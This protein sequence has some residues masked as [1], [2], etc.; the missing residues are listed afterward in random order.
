[1]RGI[2]FLGLTTVLFWL[3]VG[4]A[5]TESFL[6]RREQWWDEGGGSY[7]GREERGVLKPVVAEPDEHWREL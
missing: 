5:V 2:G 4:V 6:D 1:M 3:A 7:G